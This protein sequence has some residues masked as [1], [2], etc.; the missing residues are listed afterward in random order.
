MAQWL[1]PHAPNA[2]DLDATP[3]QE[4][5]IPRATTKTCFFFFLK[6]DAW[7]SFSLFLVLTYRICTMNSLD[8]H[9]AKEL[10]R[11]KSF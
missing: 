3:G 2:E 1:R 8:Q 7:G 9:C 4:T 10:V 6:R 5:K 11:Y